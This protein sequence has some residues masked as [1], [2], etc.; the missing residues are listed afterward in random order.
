VSFEWVIRSRSALVVGRAVCLIA[1]GGLA[2]SLGLIVYALAAQRQ[3][4]GVDWLL[5]PGVPALAVGQVWAIVVI[6]AR[7]P[8]NFRRGAM[9]VGVSDPGGRTWADARSFFFD[10]LPKRHANALVAIA[11]VGMIAALTATPWIWNGG[12]ASGT[13]GCPY[14]LNDHGVYTCVSRS[15]YNHAGAG[16]QRFACG[17]LVG[18]FAVHLGAAAAELARRR[19]LA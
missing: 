4:A 12:E 18:F 3:L 9:A 16:A 13:A 11:A 5:I 2:V 15:V 17:I 6:G 14:R 1:G 7:R 10:G 19:H 8:E